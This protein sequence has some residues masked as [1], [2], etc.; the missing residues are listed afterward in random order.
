[1]LSLA[2]DG[3]RRPSEKNVHEVGI[4]LGKELHTTAPPAERGR[5]TGFIHS[6]H[7]ALLIEG[8]LSNL[9]QTVFSV[10][11]NEG[12]SGFRQRVHGALGKSARID[13]AEWNKRYDTLDESARKRIRKNIANLPRHPKI[14]V[15]MPT[16]NTPPSWLQQ[17]I[18]S[19]RC[20]LYEN[21]EL[22][23]ADDASTNPA[24]RLVLTN[25]A[26]EDDR[27][28]VI[29]RQENGHIS[30]ASNSALSLCRGEWVALMDHDDILSEHALYCVAEVVSQCPDARLIY[31]DEDKINEDGLRFDPYF[32]CGFNRDLFYSHNMI[33]HLGVYQR[34]LVRSVGGFRK[35]FEGSQDYDLA[36]RILERI[37]P[38]QII[39]IPRVLYHWRRHGSST[40]G[41]AASK[42]YARTAAKRAIE[43]HLAR[44]GTPAEITVEDHG[45][46]VTYTLPSPEPLVSI[47]VIAGNEAAG[48]ARFME[49]V[50]KVTEYRNLELRIVAGNPIGPPSVANRSGSRSCDITNI[51]GY[52]LL[53]EQLATINAAV[54]D[55]VGEYIAFLGHEATTVS[56]KWLQELVA[57]AAQPGVGSVSAKILDTNG[58]V[59]HAGYV[60]G[61]GGTVGS[62]FHRQPRN[63]PCYFGRAQ[64]ISGFSATSGSCMVIKKSRFQQVGGYEEHKLS[65]ALANVDLC[66]RLRE[67]GYRSIL[68]PNAWL[69][70][71]AYSVGSDD[72]RESV[73]LTNDMQYMNDRWGDSFSNDPCYS[74]NLTL[75][76]ED[77]SFAWP[78]RVEPL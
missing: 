58:T 26:A 37:K 9:F 50:L 40:A 12:W 61:I 7:N 2:I 74:P 34:K 57:V 62:A 70:R 27:I 73:Q 19:V 72:E 20:Q 64:L 39:H 78:P 77:F 24:T 30:A 18:D 67:A 71:P 3:T 29:F 25:A 55:C 5:V 33:S 4:G 53:S 10:L 35:T 63:S 11:K 75:D 14:S 45:Y 31:S 54:N 38:E 51:Y 52:N 15:L 68:N 13:Y 49:N 6:F 41:G 65:I 23:I 66:L 1:M 16:F 76:F 46:R 60:L 28:K 22:C 48:L 44:L 17:A 59:E 21:W 42:P 43:E 56:S 47:V 8:G 36:L 69:I 32:K